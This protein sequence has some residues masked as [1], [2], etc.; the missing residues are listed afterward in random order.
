MRIKTLPFLLAAVLMTASCGNAVGVNRKPSAQKGESTVTAAEDTEVPAEDVQP[1]DGD[2]EN[3]DRESVENPA[4]T[5]EDAGTAKKKKSDEGRTGKTVVSFACAGDNLI[6]DNI[7]VDAQKEDGSYDFSKCYA[8]CKKLIE[9]VDVAVLNQET[10][11]NDAFPPSTFP[12]FSTPTEVGDA[13]V[14]FG[15]N[16]ISMCNNHVLDMGS[17]GLIS[18][19]DYWDSKDVVHY[20]AYRDEADAEDIRTM[21]IDGVTF[22]FLGYM[23]HTNGIFLSDDEPGEAVY[24]EERDRIERQVRAAD[25]IADVVVVSCHFGTE[26]L[27]DLNNMQ[28]EFAPQLVEWGADLIIGTQAHAL[29]TCEYIDKPD[30]GKAFCYYGLGNF[31]STMYDA[32]NPDGQYGRAIIGIFGKLDVVK[33]YD[34]GGAISFENVKAIPVI[35]HYEGDSWESMWYNC[36]VYPYGDYTD[37]MFSRHMMYQRAGV[38]RNTLQNYINYIPEEF[39]AYE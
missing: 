28:I 5:D 32:D 39:L 4:E 25:E 11:V 7:Y 27:N 15:F 2:N 23:E 26:V 13:V 29:S 14:D 37:E 35:S 21:E 20:G 8:P 16:V 17:T 38:N 24:I 30:G 22:A 36:A 6:H 33:D 10:V 12:M 9:G 34:N 19:L 31:F 1:A 18:S 3:D